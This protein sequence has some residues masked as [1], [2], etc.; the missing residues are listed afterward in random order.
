[1]RAH[2]RAHVHVGDSTGCLRKSS[3]A[4][5]VA[6][7]RINSRVNAHI[8]SRGKISSK[9]DGADETERLLADT[10]P[11]ERLAQRKAAAEGV[12]MKEK[13]YPPRAGKSVIA[14]LPRRGDMWMLVSMPL[15]PIWQCWH[16][17]VRKTVE[18]SPPAGAR[19]G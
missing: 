3:V 10:R 1:M 11:A 12:V 15:C 17:S 18:C 9:P 8:N 2:R 19:N 4:A 5:A 7:A 16:P 14:V 6:D 13:R